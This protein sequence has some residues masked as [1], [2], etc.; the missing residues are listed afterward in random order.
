MQETCPDRRLE[1]IVQGVKLEGGSVIGYERA[2]DDGNPG[3]IVHVSEPTLP[4]TTMVRH[5]VPDSHLDEPHLRQRAHDGIIGKY[6]L[7]LMP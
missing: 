7:G 1:W 6:R 4:E 5:L 3:W 2:E